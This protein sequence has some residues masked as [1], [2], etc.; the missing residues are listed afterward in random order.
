[1]KICNKKSFYLGILFLIG[2]LII[3]F[4]PDSS[5]QK[6]NIFD[7]WIGYLMLL[8]LGIIFISYGLYP[9]SFLGKIGKKIYDFFIWVNKKKQ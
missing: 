3:Y 9:K 4:V 8:F 6:G 2:L 7:N 5:A 1:M